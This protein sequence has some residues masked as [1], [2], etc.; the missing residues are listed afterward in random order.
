MCGPLPS[1]HRMFI[2]LFLYSSANSSLKNRQKEAK[3]SHFPNSELK[4]IFWE[5]L[6]VG[7]LKKNTANF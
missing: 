7:D 4:T 6:L 3:I 1:G 2:I 5:I